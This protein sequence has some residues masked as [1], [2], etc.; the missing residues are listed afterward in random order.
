MIFT[1]IKDFSGVELSEKIFKDI[2]NGNFFKS[3]PDN[4]KNVNWEEYKRYIYPEQSSLKI[5]K[6]IKEIILRL[7]ENYELYV[8]SSGGTKNISDCLSN[9]EITNAFIDVLGLETHKLKVDKFKF[10]FDKYNLTPDDCIFVTDTLGDIL[11]ANIVNIKTI[12][13][14]FGFHNK[15]TLKKGNPYRIISHLGEL[16]G[17]IEKS[18]MPWINF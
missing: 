16:Q 17:I 1:E 18:L 12:A 9:N 6:E 13:V 4:I 10:I 14:D 5:K 11:E 8:V 15:E 3:I 7:K 2:H